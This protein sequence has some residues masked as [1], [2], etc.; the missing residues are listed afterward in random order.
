MY[1]PQPRRP[2]G[3]KNSIGDL[4]GGALLDPNLTRELATD[5]EEENR[6]GE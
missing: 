1:T 3:K 6:D 4:H 5:C 2:C